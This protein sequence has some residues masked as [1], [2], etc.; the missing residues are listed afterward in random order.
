MHPSTL[1]F[2]TLRTLGHSSLLFTFQPGTVTCTYGDKK[3]LPATAPGARRDWARRAGVGY[4]RLLPP[5]LPGALYLHNKRAGG[6]GGSP[7][8][9]GEGRAVYAQSWGRGLGGEIG[10]SVP[11]R[12]RGIRYRKNSLPFSLPQIQSSGEGRGRKQQ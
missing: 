4:G 9:R 2:G 8:P 3:N 11:I 7:V 12:A 5:S 6:G 10:I 1:P